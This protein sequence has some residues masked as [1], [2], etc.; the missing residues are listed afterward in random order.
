MI[1]LRCFRT[2]RVNFAIRNYVFS[3]RFFSLLCFI[4]TSI[5]T[6]LNYWF[7]FS[8]PHWQYLKIL[9]ESSVFK[10]RRT[11]FQGAILDIDTI[12]VHTNII[13][14]LQKWSLRFHCINYHLSCHS[15]IDLLIKSLE[16]YWSKCKPSSKLLF[17]RSREL[18][19]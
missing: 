2:D 13:T 7:G 10:K 17:N 3:L 18:R 8:W 14:W 5:W 1:V 19:R 9:K 12:T 11:T 15:R 6:L 16:Y 4:F